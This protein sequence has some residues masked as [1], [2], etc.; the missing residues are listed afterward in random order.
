MNGIQNFDN[1]DYLTLILWQGF[2]KWAICCLHTKPLFFQL[3]VRMSVKKKKI[4][5][6]DQGKI[7]LG[8]VS[9]G[10]AQILICYAISADFLSLSTMDGS[11]WESGYG[12]V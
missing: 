11:K 4:C 1:V 7:L 12:D 10:I 2:S 5:S 6:L 8:T 9:R 3:H